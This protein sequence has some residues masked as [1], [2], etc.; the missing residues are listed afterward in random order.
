MDGEHTLNLYYV[1]LARCTKLE[2]V[3]EILNM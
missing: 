3:Y 2:M 1:A